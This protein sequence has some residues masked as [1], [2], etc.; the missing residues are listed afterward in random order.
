MELQIQIQIQKQIQPEFQI[1][2]HN[3]NEVNIDGLLTLI[4]GVAAVMAGS[5]LFINVIFLENLQRGLG[6]AES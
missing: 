6:M 3:L 2:I 4:Y 5:A 1:Q